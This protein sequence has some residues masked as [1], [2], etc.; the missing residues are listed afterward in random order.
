MSSTILGNLGFSLA[1]L[2]ASSGIYSLAY[3]QPV[4]NSQPTGSASLSKAWAYD[5]VVA[6]PSLQQA[7]TAAVALAQI[8]I[9]LYQAKR[10]TEQ[11]LCGGQWTPLGPFVEQQGPTIGALPDATY[12]SRVSW[13]FNSLRHPQNLSCS[14]VSRTRFFMEMSRHLP[15]WIQIRPAGQFT[16][17]QQGNPI[18]L[19]QMAFSFAHTSRPH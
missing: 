18:L 15:E 9:A 17:F 3:S 12:N 2:L 5:Q 1:L 13:R 14:N 7:P 11:S 16:A 10:N 6:Y 8:N 19:Q 4:Q